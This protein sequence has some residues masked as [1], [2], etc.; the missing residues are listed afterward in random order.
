[1]PE[2][3]DQDTAEI[4]G[5]GVHRQKVAPPVD[6]PVAEELPVEKRKPVWLD[7]PSVADQVKLG[8]EFWKL[9]RIEVKV[10]DFSIPSQLD[11]FNSLLTRTNTPGSNVVVV[12]DERKWSDKTDNWKACVELQFIKY[13][14]I[15]K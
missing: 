6:E 1:M 11:E 9:D 3:L 5:H 7:T 8:E 2:A 15:I 12:K 14:Q 13:L 10:F 4:V